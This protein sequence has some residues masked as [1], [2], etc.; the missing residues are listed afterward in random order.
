MLKYPRTNRTRRGRL[1][2]DGCNVARIKDWL[3]GGR[4]IAALALAALLAWLATRGLPDGRLH[5]YFLDVGQGDAVFVRTPH[6]QQLLIDGGPSPAALLTQLA[7]VMPFWDRSLDVVALTHADADH[8]T[9][10]LAVL[11]GYRVD[12]VVDTPAVAA[13]LAA[14]AWR[15]AREGAARGHVMAERGLQLATD[16]ANLAVLHPGAGAGPRAG[17]DESLVLRLDFGQTSLLLAGDA[18]AQAEAEMLR[19]NVPLHADVLKIGHHGSANATTAPF[20]DAVAPRMAVIQVG[21]DN[22]FGHPAASALE[23]LAGIPIFRTDRAG[24]IEIISDGR[25]I[26]V[27]TEHEEAD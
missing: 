5:V 27:K 4:V 25:Q 22:R 13:D 16:G 1:L 23:R 6:G 18:E 26:W 19:E 14:A 10:L 15:A 8:M 21:Q 7:G 3:L 12:R 9:G 24:A 17:N 20:L 2:R 11:E